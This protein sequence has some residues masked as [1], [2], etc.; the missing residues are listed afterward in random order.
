MP[1]TGRSTKP[2]PSRA[3]SQRVPIYYLGYS[4]EMGYSHADFAIGATRWSYT[5]SLL[6]IGDVDFLARKVGPAKA[7][8][9]AKRHATAQVKH[10]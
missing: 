5:L 10:G 3:Q 7:L 6:R 2:K 8:A 4:H 9:L 1:E